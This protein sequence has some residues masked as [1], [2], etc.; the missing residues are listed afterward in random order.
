[1][2]WEPLATV[3]IVWLVCQLC[4]LAMLQLGSNY[5]E[6]K[7]LLRLGNLAHKQKMKALQ[8]YWP[9][10]RIRPA[11]A[12]SNIVLCQII[13]TSL[14][15]LKSLMSFAFG[16]L[17]VFWLPL[18]AFLVPSI[19]TIHQP[20]N[21]Q[22]IAKV[23]RIARWQVTSHTLAAAIGA[24]VFYCWWSDGVIAAKLIVELIFYSIVFMAGSFVCAW[25]AGKLETALLSEIEI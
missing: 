16:A 19:I 11:M 1:L 3:L 10:N 14:I 8:S 17:I 24:Y 15:A 23:K 22:L 6:N 18:A 25:K 12:N 7:T 13:L 5:I 20:G 21:I 9:L 2:N 4:A